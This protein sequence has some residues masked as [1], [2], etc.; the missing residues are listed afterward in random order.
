MVV[1]MKEKAKYTC[2]RC[3]SSHTV[4]HGY[5]RTVD[6]ELKQRRK[7]QECGHTFYQDKEA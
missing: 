1:R 2:P 6:R 5:N 7:C 3:G 4:K